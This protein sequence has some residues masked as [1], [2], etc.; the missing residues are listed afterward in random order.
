MTEETRNRATAGQ[1]IRALTAHPDEF[2]IIYFSSTDWDS[3]WQRPQQLASRLARHGHVLYVNSF[4]LR[5][6]LLKDW[7]RIAHRVAASLRQHVKSPS[8]AL[9]VLSPFFFLPFPSS[10][11]AN[12]IN[13]ALLRRSLH[14]WIEDRP[15]RALI[16]WVG[17]P[18][19]AAMEAI[20][21]LAPTLLVYDC[22]DNVAAFHRD[23]PDI[24]ETEQRLATTADLV[25]ATSA[26]LYERMKR[27]NPR[28]FRVPNAVDLAL[29]RAAAEEHRVPPRDLAAL[30]R[31]I[32]GY[33]GEIAAWLDCEAI[34]NLAA[35]NP[36]GSIVLVG[37]IHADV[38]RI[39]S[40]PNVHYLGL[41]GYDVMPK[42][43]EHFDVCLLPFKINSLTNAV[44]PI[45]LY[46]Y[47]AMGKPIVS[48]PL[49][50]IQPYHN[51]VEIAE[52][53]EF[54]AAA[55]RALATARDE[56]QIEQRLQI[57]RSNTWDLRTAQ[58]I[59]IL[60]QSIRVRVHGA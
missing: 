52:A 39:L 28:T 60:R 38:S 40:L 30:P 43:I 49:R 3:T 22:I 51:V 33:A 54:A 24:L 27:I 47:L 8:T 18:T 31:P 21:G 57:A 23:R 12:Q 35:Q 55:Q 6:P 26:D 17:I 1:T 44:N 15:S 20:Q 46:E 53:A 42:Y 7:R 32:L 48:T 29:F 50:E 11:R 34:E 13:G 2:A 58:V 19:P 16:A 10:R 45:K 37:R 14:R 9:S 25:I 59:R 41:K 5:I 4:G 56:R 36:S